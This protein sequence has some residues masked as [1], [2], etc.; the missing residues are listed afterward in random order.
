MK[1]SA[2]PPS[3]TSNRAAAKQMNA[4]GLSR[5]APKTV[6]AISLTLPDVTLS[7]SVSI[8][9]TTR[10]IPPIAGTARSSSSMP[11]AMNCTATSGQ[12]AAVTMAPRFKAAFNG[13]GCCMWARLQ[14]VYSLRYSRDRVL[15][16]VRHV[17]W[18]RLLFG[19]VTAALLALALGFAWEWRR[20]GR[21]AEGAVARADADVR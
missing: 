1:V 5:E 10:K 12:L 17:S 4:T 9:S 16:R 13:K 3:M 7:T 19:G 15:P 8:S 6:A 20:F 21:D 14:P 18:R 2:D 11:S